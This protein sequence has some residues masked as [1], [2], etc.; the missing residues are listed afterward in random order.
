MAVLPNAVSISGAVSP[1][2]REMVATVLHRSIGQG[3]GDAISGDF[4]DK[5]DVSSWATSSMA[6]AVDLGI[7]HG[8]DGLLEPQ[9][10]ITRAE[11]AAVL[12]NLAGNPSYDASRLPSDCSAGD[13]Y[14]GAVCWALQAGAFNGNPDGSF[15]PNDELTREQAA[16]VIM[17]M[18]GVLGE[19]TS[20][21]AD[22]SRFPDADEISSW[23]ADAM[24]WAVAEGIISGSDHGN[25][26]RTL[27]AQDTCSRA[28]IAAILMNWLEG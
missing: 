16:A 20:A 4:P 10:S 9:R 11:M 15:G 27:D 18:A 23:A 22:L 24:S 13:W 3:G 26:V 19:S 6:W 12:H 25:G 28:T 2:T 21:R 17:N 7:V 5:A 8:S 1:I 14:A